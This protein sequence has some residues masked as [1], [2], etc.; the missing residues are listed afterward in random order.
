M[1]LYCFP[2]QVAVNTVSCRKSVGS[3]SEGETHRSC[4]VLAFWWA[5]WVEASKRRTKAEAGAPDWDY[6][7]KSPSEFKVDP[8]LQEADSSF[9]SGKDF[10][11]CF[12]KLWKI[13]QLVSEAEKTS[14]LIC[15]SSLEIIPLFSAVRVGGNFSTQI[16]T[17][18]ISG[19]DYLRSLQR[20]CFQGQRH[21]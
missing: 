7:R 11:W 17:E 10:A 6:R 2:E 15:S 9:L 1:T 3:G 5:P 12:L 18:A 21:Y 8:Q 20:R 13:I 19:H 4:S 14:S 16:I